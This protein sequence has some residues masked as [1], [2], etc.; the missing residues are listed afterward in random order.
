MACENTLLDD[1]APEARSAAAIA[2]PAVLSRIVKDER[3][4]DRLAGYFERAEFAAGA[5]LIEEGSP[6]DDI[7]VIESGQATVTMRG[8]NGAAMV[9]ASVGPGAI[10]G[11]IPFYRERPRSASVVAETPTIAWRF[12]RAALTRLRSDSPDLAGRLHEGLAALL[13]ERLAGTDRL[14][15]FLVE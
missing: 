13:A 6:S 5:S 12:T 11:E 8:W 10:V 9:L 14:L 7:Y 2:L 4:A 15:G 1:V 3:N